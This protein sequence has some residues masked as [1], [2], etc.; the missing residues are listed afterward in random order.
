ML[1]LRNK[2]IFLVLILAG[3]GLIV[4]FSFWFLEEGRTKSS[5]A[6]NPYEK[7][8][9][10]RGKVRRIIC[11][12]PS[13]TE[14]VF[15]L[16]CGKKVIGVSDFST[17]PPQAKEKVKI[18]GMFNPNRERIIALQPDLVIIQGQHDSVA[19][20]CRKEGIRLLS[21]EID[22][23]KDIP[24]A[25]FFL[26]Q[27][28]NVESQA[29]KLA[30]EVKDGLD[31]VKAK[32]QGLPTRKVFLTLAHTPGD[33]TGLMTTGPGT[34]LHE[35]IEIAGGENIFADAS[36]TYPQIS[37]ESLIKRQPEVLIEAL[38]GGV[39]ERKRRLLRKDWERLSMLPAVRRGN[40]H[41][42][43]DD[44]LLIPSV[45][46]TQTARRFA[47]IIHPEAFDE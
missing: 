38:P 18:G 37:K 4:S 33:L 11:V 35:L 21:V 24:E 17:Y 40:I 13:V 14:I 43:T 41:F 3:L 31:A 42:L 26:G 12:A 47:E 19:K 46:I 36:G 29:A 16:G 27:E 20:L 32:I 22:T 2:P 39:S 10:P 34:F 45:R 1:D 7:M 15:A 5:Q 8:L 6:S 28:L 23:L 44:F 9:A 30:K 25:I